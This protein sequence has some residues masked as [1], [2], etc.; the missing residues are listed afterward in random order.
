[1]QFPKIFDLTGKVAV[2]TGAAGGL[3]TAFIE[4]MAEAGADCVCTDID[5]HGVKVLVEKVQQM[6]RKALGVKCDVT[7]EKDVLETMER[8]HDTFGH[9]DILFNNAGIADPVPTPIHQYSTDAWNRVLAVNLQG[10]FYC[11]REAL[12]FM[13][14]QKSGK[15]IN[16]ASSWGLAGSSIMPVPAY[17]ATKGAVVN[18]TR[19]MA[20]EYAAY[21]ITVNAICPG[22]YET[23]ISGGALYKDRNALK[24]VTDFIPMKRVAQPYELKGAAI[25]LAS[26]ASDYVTGSMLVS[27]GGMLAK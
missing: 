13:V 21:G 9:L 26:A 4:A 10:V 3:G 23:N 20:M 2:V 25:F 19:E 15:I 24:T 6:G 5:E 18:L 1:M 16:I 14:G 7:R 11:S 12:K 8:A 27:D 22:F 17:C